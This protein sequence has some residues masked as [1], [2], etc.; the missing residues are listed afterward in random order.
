MAKLGFEFRQA[1]KNEVDPNLLIKNLGHIFRLNK[2]NL[3]IYIY[4]HIHY[5]GL[6]ESLQTNQGQAPLAYKQM[7]EEN[8]PLLLFKKRL[9]C[10][11]FI[12]LNVKKLR[13]SGFRK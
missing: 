3:C 4:T 10:F 11:N 1:L 8:F 9:N 6:E 12:F 2:S 13:M 7:L 5:E